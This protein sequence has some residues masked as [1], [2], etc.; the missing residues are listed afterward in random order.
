MATFLWLKVLSVLMLSKISSKH[1][2]WRIQRQNEFKKKVMWD[3]G[4]E[5]EREMSERRN[6]IDY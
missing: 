4:D 3:A 6:E 2:V 1:E 5:N